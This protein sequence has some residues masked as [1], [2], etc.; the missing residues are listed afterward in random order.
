MKKGTKLPS[1]KMVNRQDQEIK[2]FV[3]DASGKTLGRFASE[4]AKILRGK[5]R[6]TFTPHADVGDGVIIVNAEKIRVSGKKNARKVYRRYTGYMSGLR[7]TPY[8]EMLESK[9]E[10]IVEH[11]VKGMM[12]KTKLGRS[13]LKRLRIYAKDAHNMEAQQPIQAE[14]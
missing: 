5:H 4:I 7:E 14:I 8:Q 11:A 12:P 1:T 13:Q 3:L 9:P 10:Y 2:W 6:P